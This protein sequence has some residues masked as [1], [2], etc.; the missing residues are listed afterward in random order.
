MITFDP[1][2]D[3]MN[4][5]T[6][7][8]TPASAYEMGDVDHSGEVSISDVTTLIDMILGGEEA[9]A[10]ADCDGQEGVGIGDVTALI[11]YL[12]SGKW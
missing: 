6:F 12:V 2:A 3:D 10:E 11:D 5:I 8:A 7:T 9:P 1:A 4:K